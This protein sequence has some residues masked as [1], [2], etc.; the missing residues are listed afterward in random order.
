[1][2]IS[3]LNTTMGVSELI[4]SHKPNNSKALVA[5]NMCGLDK[6]ASIFSRL[7]SSVANLAKSFGAST[8]SVTSNRNFQIISGASVASLLAL[9]AMYKASPHVKDK[10]NEWKKDGFEKD[11]VHGYEMKSLKDGTMM[12]K[13]SKEQIAKMN[14]SLEAKP[15]RSFFGIKG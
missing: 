1:M 9:F 7:A 6:P 8:Y 11:D 15:S 13:A 14:K 3:R 10:Y 4:N 12:I 5:L 2:S